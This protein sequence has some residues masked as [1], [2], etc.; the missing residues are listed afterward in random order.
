MS[1]FLLAS[2]TAGAIIHKGVELGLVFGVA[3]SLRN[4]QSCAVRLAA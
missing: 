4:L 2:R 1:S 3:Q